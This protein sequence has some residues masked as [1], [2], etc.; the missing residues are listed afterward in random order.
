MKKEDMN[1]ASYDLVAEM[2]DRLGV[3]GG[4]V[5]NYHQKMLQDG[6]KYGSLSYMRGLKMLQYD[7]LYG[8][9]YAYN[10]KNP[11]PATNIKMG[12]NDV[13]IDRVY[14]YDNRVHLF[15]ENFTR[16]SKVFVNGK[17]VSTKYKSGQHLSISVDDVRQGDK[18]QVCQMGSGDDVLRSS[19]KVTY[20]APAV[21]A[22]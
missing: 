14:T 22:Q 8:K 16:W 20:S 13:K 7:L 6:V 2:F 19:N 15:G 3:H 11:Y 18:I 21:S 10:G 17:Q 4:T 1:L 5:M 9:R 12:I